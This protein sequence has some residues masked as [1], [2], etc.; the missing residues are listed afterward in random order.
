MFIK[1]SQNVDLFIHLWEIFFNT[2]LIFKINLSPA[3]LQLSGATN[4]KKN[5][6]NVFK[7]HGCKG[8]ISKDF[9]HVF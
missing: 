2:A 1:Q 7:K 4:I 8:C 9:A 3:K 6:I 5:G